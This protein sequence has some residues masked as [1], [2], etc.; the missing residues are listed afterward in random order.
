[1]KNQQFINAGN[2]RFV[3]ARCSWRPA[4]ERAEISRGAAFGDIDNDGDV[5]IVVT[6]NSGPVRLL[7]N[8]GTPGNHWIEIALQDSPHNRFGFG[9]R[10]GIER[11]GKPTVWRRV[12]TDGS[13]LSAS[14]VR[15]H[16]GL[17]SSAAIDGIVVQ[18]VDGARER[19]TK[20]DADRLVTLRRGTGVKQ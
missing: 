4:F 11:G 17:G 16:A 8:Q 13:Y 10:V 14:D 1:M 12:G 20:T 2:G 15:A 9:A 5:D 3:D 7:I 19:W 6:N 18:W